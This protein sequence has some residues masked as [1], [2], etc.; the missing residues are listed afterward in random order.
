LGRRRQI[1]GRNGFC[2]GSAQPRYIAL[3]NR[4]VVAGRDI[5][6]TRWVRVLVVGECDR[7]LKGDERVVVSKSD[8]RCVGVGRGCWV[9]DVGPGEAGWILLKVGEASPSLR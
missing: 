5:G 2:L 7:V 6:G 1:R 4:H 8:V 3:G 9:R